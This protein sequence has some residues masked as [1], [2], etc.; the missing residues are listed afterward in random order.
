MNETFLNLPTILLLLGVAM[1]LVGG[2]L[3]SRVLMNRVRA[4]QAQERETGQA[5]KV[6]LEPKALVI[7]SI[8]SG[9]GIILLVTSLTLP[10]S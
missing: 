6:A 3:A 9:L 5:V 1:M 4:A 2:A 7:P 8:V 10:I